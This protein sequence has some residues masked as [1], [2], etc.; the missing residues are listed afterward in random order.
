MKLRPRMTEKQILVL[1]AEKFAHKFYLDNNWSVNTEAYDQLAKDALKFA[2]QIQRSA[3]RR[4]R[5][6]NKRVHNM[7][8]IKDKT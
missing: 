4:E 3:L 8:E 5:A 7:F 1:R 2:A 6:R